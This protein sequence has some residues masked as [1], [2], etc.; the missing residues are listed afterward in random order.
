MSSSRPYG[1]AKPV[2][3]EPDTG[4]SSTDWISNNRTP[5]LWFET[6][7]ARPG[8]VVDVTWTGTNLWYP[9]Q[10][11]A[12]TNRWFYQMTTPL[13]IGEPQITGR[14]RDSSGQLGDEWGQKLEILPAVAPQM[15]IIDVYVDDVGSSQGEFGSN[16]PTDDRTLTLRGTV[17]QIFFPKASGSRAYYKLILYKDGVQLGEVTQFDQAAGTWE[18][19]LDASNPAEFIDHGE[20]GVFTLQIEDIAGGKSA[21]T[22]GFV[23]NVDLDITVDFQTTSNH[24]PTITGNFGFEMLPGEYLEITVDGKTYSSQRGEVVLDNATGKWSIKV[25]SIDAILPGTYDVV[26]I[27]HRA[28]GSKVIND[29][30][31]NELTILDYWPRLTIDSYVD[32]V[33]KQQGEFGSGVPTDDRTLTLRGTVDDRFLADIH[34]KINNPTTKQTYYKLELFVERPGG[35]DYVGEVTNIDLVTGK[36]EFVLDPN[37]PIHFIDHGEQAT[38]RVATHHMNS[39]NDASSPLSPGFV[40]NVDLEVGVDFQTTASHT[41]LITGDFAFEVLTQK[42]EYVEVSVNGKTY[43]SKTGQVLLDDATGKWQVQIPPNDAI[44]SGVYDV[45]A[46]LHRADGS[47]VVNDTTLDEL[48]ILAPPPPPP[49]PPPAPPSTIDVGTGSGS[50]YETYTAV[51]LNENGQW[52]IATNGGLMNQRATDIYNLGR[53]DIT[54]LRALD[55][56]GGQNATFIDLNRNGLMDIVINDADGKNGQQVFIN[57][58]DGTYYSTQISGAANTNV[59]YGG[60]IGIDKTG[61]GYV[62][63]AYGDARPYGSSNGWDSQIV[64]NIDGNLTSMVK[65]RY[66]TDAKNGPNRQ[67]SLNWGNAQAAQ[68]ISGV[69]LNNDGTVDLIFH[70]NTRS[71]TVKQSNGRSTGTSSNEYRLVVASNNGDGSYRTSQVIDDVFQNNKYANYG[72]ANGVSMTW[73]DFNGDGYMDLFISRGRAHDG[74]N[75]NFYGQRHGE[76]ESRI[77]F[78]DGHG[79]LGSTNVNG[80]GKATDVHWMGDNQGGGASLAVDWNGDGKMD[81]IELPAYGDRN[82]VSF[83]DNTGPVTLYTNVSRNGVINFTTSNLL[84][85]NN[86]IGVN[87]TV[88]TKGRG[89]TVPTNDAD[90]VTG[91]V[92]AD[93]DWN[94]AL[95]LLVFTRWGNTQTIMNNNVIEDGTSLHLRIL[96]DEGVNSFF[97]NTVQLVDSK[98]KIVS[99]QI[100]NPQSGN[101]T[102]D[103]TGLVHFYGLD[104]NETYSVVL[105][106]SVYGYSADVGGVNYVGNNR[107]ENVNASW[108]GLKAGKPHEAHILTAESGN[109]IANATVVGTGY[110]D[111]FYATKGTNAYDG[112]GGTTFVQGVRQWSSTGG[113]DIIDFKLAGNQSI[114]VDLN[115]TSYQNTGWNTVKLVNIEGVSGG[116]GDDIFIANAG[117]N[118]FNGR[119]GDDSFYL[120]AGGHNTLVYE[121]IDSTNDTGG[122]GHDIVYDFSIG[123]PIYPDDAD[124]IDLS[125]LLIGYQ[126]G[127]SDIHDFVSLRFDG[128][129]TIL[130]VDIDGAANGHGFADMITFNNV[131]FDLL[132]LVNN[133]QIIV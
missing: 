93:L 107:I 94:G 32:D 88:N 57:R 132:T 70:A 69:D 127:I 118:V 9:A 36:W 81:I 62:D 111:T 100:I 99:A 20:Q 65:D 59:E 23:V 41:P 28:D 95:D 133:H 115:Y 126:A 122:N 38:F 37:N 63:I 51:T 97:G 53:F 35:Y 105:L 27:L 34:G 117:D 29:K 24:S 109:N 46:I 82:G 48:T 66:F 64:V 8:D 101:Q 39:H 121:L 92:V 5:K 43:S 125:G 120:G 68:E 74:R 10:Y 12:A 103:S 15:A 84:G 85:G 21:F 86:T 131:H 114:K 67:K 40:V 79:N 47:T 31:L 18:Y 106:R 123:D 96:D 91:A 108:G 128:A 14:L 113:V 73:A 90:F 44:P 56:K 22:P 112:A 16:V 129:D 89:T 116:N 61:N 76:N 58:G 45:V 110:N 77:L 26:A 55:A 13:P 71:S 54:D 1:W 119:G 50:L 60:V 6:I 83:A 87:G 52:S 42:G 33:G 80:V 78:N 7:D 11:D 2:A 104:P 4:V 3:L 17:E 72:V 25:S 19:V 30:T 102:N 75:G 98:G 49:P 130:S 124:V